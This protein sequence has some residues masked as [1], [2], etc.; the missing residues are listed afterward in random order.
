[1]WF[2]TANGA[3]QFSPDKTIT[4]GLEP[5]T[6]IMSM[7]VNNEIREMSPGMTL[8]YYEKSILFDYYSICLTNP[9]VV[10]YKI[11]LE[12]AD[13]N[14]QPVIIQFMCIIILVN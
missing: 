11:K 1:M 4:K 8:N 7:R 13:E 12:G 2:G 5:L 14:W 3:T 6:H 10:R 9:D